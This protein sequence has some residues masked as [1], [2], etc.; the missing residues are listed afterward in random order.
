VAFDGVTDR[1][2]ASALTGTTLVVES[3]DL[4]PTENPDEFHDA[5]LLGLR[6]HS[7]DGA[8]IGELADIVHGPGGD[9]LVVRVEGREVLVPFV[10]EMVPT[11]D[12]R[13]GR[14]VID[15]PEGLLEL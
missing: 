8:D 4:P 1:A 15:P 11:V 3:A 9:L 14:V 2:A 12:V 7:V 6:V 5:D 13:A 10:R